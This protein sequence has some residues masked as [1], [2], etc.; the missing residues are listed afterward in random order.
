MKK[1]KNLP[2]VLIILDGWGIAP[3]A[4]GN[5]ISRAKTPHF[6]K[7]VATYPSMRLAASGAYVGLSTHLPGNSE[8][9]HINI[10]TGR[11]FQQHADIINQAINNGDFFE[12]EAFLKAIENCKKNR[13]KIHLVGLL[14]QTNK[15]SKIE[16][17]YALLK[18]FKKYR[19]TRVFLHLIVDGV[20]TSKI[21]GLENLK[22]LIDY[23]EEIKSPAQIASICGRQ[24]AMN[25][26]CDWIKTQLAYNAMALG[27]GEQAKDP[28]SILS[29]SYEN[30]IHDE[31]I[32]PANISFRNKAISKI[33]NGDSVIFFNY[34]NDGMRQ[35]V[36]SFVL[37]EFNKFDRQKD[38]TNTVFC[39]M[40]KY[41]PDLPFDLVAFPKIKIK[42]S[43]TEV[44]NKDGL[45]QLNIAETEKFPH[46]T[47]YF[48]G[49]Q[50]LEFTHYD[51]ILVPSPKVALFNK[52][53]EMSANKITDEVLRAL[54]ENKYDF[55]TVN[56][57]NAD[58]V[59]HSED[60]Q[61]TIKACQVIDKCLGKI[62]PVVLSKNGI[63]LICGDHGNAE[64]MQNIQTSEVDAG[65]SRNDVPFIM[66]SNSWEGK[67][68]GVPD[69]L[70]ADLSLVKPVGK[71]ADIAPTIL[72]I[73]K[74]EKPDDMT[75]NNLIN[76]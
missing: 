65:H 15:H 5:A 13:T 18:I 69:S 73:L 28:L 30:E 67:T 47:Y 11:I 14:S 76:L 2:I 54:S 57:A 9:G 41:A 49:E 35:L 22:N 42:N 52:K 68:G 27:L 58:I 62:V 8:I 50:H 45:R 10:G 34:R 63:V 39:A 72:N 37:P 20:D 48:N 25:R 53:P 40:V 59:A 17:V 66:I 56:F 46:V 6:D 55:L 64:E 7:Y 61:A 24:Y 51:E 29:T 38:F 32:K 21:S 31:D 3:D 19:L 12:N 16:H 43:L 4:S 75:G 23:I 70:G 1:Y 74:I 33:D 36:K 26:Q 44:L 71:L 60:F